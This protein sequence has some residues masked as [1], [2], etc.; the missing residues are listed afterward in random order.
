MTVSVPTLSK[1]REHDTDVLHFRHRLSSGQ[2]P[3]ISHRRP[4]TGQ[5]HLGASYTNLDVNHLTLDNLGHGIPRS[6]DDVAAILAE[7]LLQREQSQ[8]EAR[9]LR[10][11]S[12]AA[13]LVS[14]FG[15]LANNAVTIR[16]AGDTIANLN[17]QLA[18][19]QQALNQAQSTLDQDNE[20]L[21]TATSNHDEAVVAFQTATDNL[22]AINPQQD[23]EGYATALAAFNDAQA[24]ENAT[25]SARD[26]ATEK[27]D[28][29]NKSI[30]LL[31]ADIATLPSRITTAT[32]T[33]GGL[34]GPSSMYSPRSPPPSM[35]SLRPASGS[36]SL[37]IS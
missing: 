6:P 5:R 4:G 30:Q 33:Y 36:P 13:R 10:A 1:V 34:V 11:Q 7:A 27:V 15:F 20:K 32:A 2:H 35:V 18:D 26:A 22:A 8:G 19:R 9:N 31:K 14:A 24:T 12:I 21:A 25:R 3:A 16:G 23:P 28:D 29:D 37:W 17:T